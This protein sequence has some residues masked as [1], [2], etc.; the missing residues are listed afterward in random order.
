MKR[1][2]LRKIINR[3]ACAKNFILGKSSLNTYPNEINIEPT[4]KC[5]M[6]CKFCAR[7]NLTRANCD[8]DFTKFCDITDE[9]K[10]HTDA[11]K[12]IGIG[13]PLLHPNIAEMIEYAHSKGI[14]TYL[15]TNGLKLT[16]E[17]WLC[18]LNVH[19]LSFQQYLGEAGV[20][21]FR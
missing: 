19:I 12:F 21:L 18:L 2:A 4:N 6:K 17:M 8:M 11:F 16:P 15:T 3:F 13:E 5:N 10:E 1:F 9:V 14:T 7:H 20:L